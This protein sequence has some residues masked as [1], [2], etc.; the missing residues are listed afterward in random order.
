MMIGQAHKG[1]TGIRFDDRWN[2]SPC[3]RLHHPVLAYLY[4]EKTL[5]ALGQYNKDQHILYL[6]KSA[7]QR[8][9]F[10]TPFHLENNSA[11]FLQAIIDTLRA[12]NTG[13]LYDRDKNILA[14]AYTADKLSGD[15][16][17]KAIDEIEKELQEIRN[18]TTEHTCMF[19]LI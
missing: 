18:F 5:K 7:L 8:P 17:R 3:E 10:T 2:T 4:F 6:L 12:F 14:S 9:A 16:Y 11:D 15:I 13:K 1:L 19:V